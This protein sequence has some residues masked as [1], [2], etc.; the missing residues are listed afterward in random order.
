MLLSEHLILEALNEEKYLIFNEPALVDEAKSIFAYGNVRCHALYYERTKSKGQSEFE[1]HAFA[2][3]TLFKAERET[4]KV[5]VAQY[6]REMKHAALYDERDAKRIKRD[7][8]VFIDEGIIPKVHDRE[9]LVQRF[10][11]YCLQTNDRLVGVYVTEN[12]KD[13]IVVVLNRRPKYVY[14]V[15]RANDGWFNT[16]IVQHYSFEL[17]NLLKY[18]TLDV[19]PIDTYAAIKNYTSSLMTTAVREKMLDRFRESLGITP[20]Q[21]GSVFAKFNV[22][23]F[24]RNRQHV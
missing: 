21:K 5:K 10:Y 9:D 17:L 2:T 4:L 18:G 3:D 24:N 8:L 20:Q 22:E 7:A 1:S 13:K 19:Q 16:R 14:T 15:F 23:L 6:N 11:P 12:L